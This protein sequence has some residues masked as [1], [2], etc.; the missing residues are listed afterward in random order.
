MY[1]QKRILIVCDSSHTLLNF[2]GKLMGKMALKNEVHVFTPRI[3]QENVQE[4]LLEMGV[5]IHISALNGSNVSVL[6]DLRFI[7]SLYKLIKKLKP[8]V[9]FPYTFKP[10]IY[11]TFLAKYRRVKL[12][13]PMLTGLGYNFTSTASG[14]RLVKRITHFL[15]KSSLRP[16]DALRVIFQ[17]NDDLNTL[18]H[19]KILNQKHQAYVVNGSGVDLDHYTYALP[20]TQPLI[21]LMIARLINAKGISEY[22]E[23]AKSI[24]RRFPDVVFKLIGPYHDNIDAIDHALYKKIV[25]REVIDYLGELDDVRF[26]IEHSSVMVLPSYYGEGVPRSVLEGMSM[27]RPVITCDS[28]GCR[29]TINP[30]PNQPNGFLIP[31]KNVTALVEKMEHFI[32]HS[33]DVVQYGKQA[34][35]YAKEKFDV[36]IVNAEL[37]KIMQLE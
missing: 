7:I 8:H 21:F 22:Y 30:D 18:K 17:N 14:N 20:S 10:V 23:A 12:I 11:G 31:V 33:K 25:N 28:V 6:S 35:S 16:S 29:E 37:F 34:R 5:F 2:R 32:L 9:F 13:T 36:N 27:G 26:Q 4:K 19:L 1:K 3:E 24:R 15:L